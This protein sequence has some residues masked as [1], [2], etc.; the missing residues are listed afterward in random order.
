MCKV[1]CI[2]RLLR[3]HPHLFC[4]CPPDLTC[5]ENNLLKSPAISVLNLPMSRVARALREWSLC[6]FGT[7]AFICFMPLL[8]TVIFNTQKITLHCHV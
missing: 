5:T 8:L 4:F 3:L 2:Q 6:I 1:R 7:Q